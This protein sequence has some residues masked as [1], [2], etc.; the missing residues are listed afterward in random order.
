[1]L[2]CFTYKDRVLHTADSMQD[3]VRGDFNELS[4]LL[5]DHG[6]KVWSDGQVMQPYAS[7]TLLCSG[8][9][10]TCCLCLGDEYPV[11]LECSLYPWTSLSFQAP[12]CVFLL[13]I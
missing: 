6:G 9:V 1:M 10:F 13:G 12:W 7:P 8:M 5:I 4:K 3:A 11:S 2:G